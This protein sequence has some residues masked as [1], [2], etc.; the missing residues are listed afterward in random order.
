M[1]EY[2]DVEK[3]VGGKEGRF[4]RLRSRDGPKKQILDFKT[5]HYSN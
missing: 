2:R 3:K 1:N 5:I 4:V